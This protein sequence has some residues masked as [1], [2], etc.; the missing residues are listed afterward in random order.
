MSVI[1]LGS[2]LFWLVSY[3]HYCCCSPILWFSVV[4]AVTVH[5]VYHVAKKTLIII[6]VE[7]IC[8]RCRNINSKER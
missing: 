6:Y 4:S 5:M 1:Y 3:F 2:V 7:L 8:N